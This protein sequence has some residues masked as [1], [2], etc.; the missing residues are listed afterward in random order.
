[1]AAEADFVGSATEVAVS[2]T[3]RLAAGSVLGTVY[4]MGVPLRLE[5]VESVPQGIEEH[6]IA[7]A[8]PAFDESYVTVAVTCW[9]PPGYTV[10]APG[11]TENTKF[12][13][14]RRAH[15]NVRYLW[16]PWGTMAHAW[17]LPT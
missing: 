8:T 15:K 1:M 7:Q 10:A 11:E 9:E 16:C 5:V 2:V 12:G 6:V 4:G 17:T 3:L 13:G 14:R